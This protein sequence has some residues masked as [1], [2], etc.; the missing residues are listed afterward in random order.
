[1]SWDETF[2]DRYEEWSASMTADIAFYV[3]LARQ[4]TGSLGELAIGNHRK[5][6]IHLAIRRRFSGELVSAEGAP[7]KSLREEGVISVNPRNELLWIVQLNA[8]EQRKQ[9]ND[10][11]TEVIAHLNKIEAKLN[12]GISV[13]ERTIEPSRAKMTVRAIGRNSFPSIPS[14]VRIGR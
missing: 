9:L 4:A 7:Q 6:T 12:T 5:E 1:M 2:A 11:L 13:N 14:S 10:K 3:E 8:G